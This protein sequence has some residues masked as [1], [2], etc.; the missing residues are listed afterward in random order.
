MYSWLAG[1]L[2]GRA[3]REEL[4]PEEDTELREL[5]AELEQARYLV[6]TPRSSRRRHYTH[7]TYYG[8]AYYGLELEQAAGAPLRRLS[9]GAG[10]EQLYP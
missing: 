6:I 3:A 5:V 8:Y 10:E 7:Y 9:S 4:T 1:N 2:Y